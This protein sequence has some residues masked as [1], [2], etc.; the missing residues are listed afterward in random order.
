MLRVV[1]S[2]L[3]S[4]DARSGNALTLCLL[5]PKGTDTSSTIFELDLPWR[6]TMRA[7]RGTSWSYLADYEVEISMGMQ[8]YPY[9]SKIDTGLGL[10]A[11]WVPSETHREGEVEVHIGSR[12]EAPRFERFESEVTEMLPSVAID[13]PHVNESRWQGRLPAVAGMSTV[14]EIDSVVLGT[15]LIRTS[16][17]GTPVKR[18]RRVA[19]SQEPTTESNPLLTLQFELSRHEERTHRTGFSQIAHGGWARA[20]RPSQVVGGMVEPVHGCGPHLDRRHVFR[21]DG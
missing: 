9:R 21:S 10:S 19:P 4:L 17:P 7:F 13:I 6:A 3:D 14:V 2:L 5:R 16:A 15:L 11:V 8:L 1:E 20:R 18:W 12:P